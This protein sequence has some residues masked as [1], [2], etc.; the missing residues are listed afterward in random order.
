MPMSTSLLYGIKS[1]CLN[2]PA[3]NSHHQT[4]ANLVVPFYILMHV[5]TECISKIQLL[6]AHL[7]HVMYSRTNF[8]ISVTTLILQ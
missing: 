7:E 4:E 2:Q 8:H 5:I 1:H 3:T 6:L